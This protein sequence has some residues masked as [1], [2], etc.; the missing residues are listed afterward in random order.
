MVAARDAVVVVYR[1]KHPAGTYTIVK[2]LAD[3]RVEILIVSP[4]K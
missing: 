2:P 3:G 1:E 4:K